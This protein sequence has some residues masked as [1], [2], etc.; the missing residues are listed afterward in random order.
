[1]RNPEENIIRMINE[2]VEVCDKKYFRP[3]KCG[4]CQNE[5]KGSCLKCFRDIHFD[6]LERR[7]NCKNSIYHYVCTYIFKYSSEIKYLFKN[8]SNFQ[9]LK[10]FDVMSI[11]CGPCSDLMA[12]SEY[13]TENK[14]VKPFKYLG[15][16]LNELWG[17]IYFHIR[18]ILKPY[19]IELEFVCVDV[20]DKFGILESKPNILIMSYVISDII[21]HKQDPNLF[22][23]KVKDEIIYKMPKNSYIILNDVDRPW[24]S[25][26]GPTGH[27]DELEKTLLNE[28]KFKFHFRKFNFGNYWSYGGSKNKHNSNNLLVKLPDDIR[29]QYNSWDECGS[30][31]LIIVKEN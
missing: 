17:L 25:K 24:Y 10:Y 6:H 28:K 14:D 1:M 7:Y 12:I 18:K 2:L 15:I 19:D 11:G 16:D 8:F 29:I 21:N 4:N 23:E 5:C 27:F 3:V 30:A 22:L 9:K 26:K 20:F 31:Q 13:M